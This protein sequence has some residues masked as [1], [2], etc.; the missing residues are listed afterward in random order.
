MK[1]AT[2]AVLA[3]GAGVAVYWG[4]LSAGF[5]GDDFMILHRLREGGSLLRFFHGEFFDYYRPLGFVAH[6]ID[7]R[8]AGASAARA[9]SSC[10]TRR[11]SAGTRMPASWQ[12]TS[13][14][15]AS[16]ARSAPAPIPSACNPSRTR[17]NSRSSRWTTS[18]LRAAQR[19]SAHS[20]AVPGTSSSSPGCAAATSAA[21]PCKPAGWLPG[22]DSNQR[23][24]D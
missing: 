13:P 5:V 12:T 4:A 8:M 18:S 16:T 7:Y 19:S 24:T 11:A 1:T 3:A 2:A 21:A 15:S 6:A 22:L 23:P 20:V 14:M 10:R 9:A 17:R